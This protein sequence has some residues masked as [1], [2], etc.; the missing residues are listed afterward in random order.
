MT[1]PLLLLHVGIG[2]PITMLMI[3][4]LT[5]RITGNEASLKTSAAMHALGR[6][7]EPEEVA[8]AIACTALSQVAIVRGSAFARLMN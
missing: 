4:P 1:V 3:N 7:G 5:A 6:V 2:L 8:S